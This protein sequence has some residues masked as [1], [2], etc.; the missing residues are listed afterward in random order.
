MMINKLQYK[1][2]PTKKGKEDIMGFI[3]H[4]INDYKINYANRDH[5]RD[6][7]TSQFS[8]FKYEEKIKF[9]DEEEKE[10][11][12]KYNKYIIGRIATNVLLC[13]IKQLDKEL[14]YI[15]LTNYNNFYI[16]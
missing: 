1:V 8:A 12:G 6:E 4:L 16:F 14:I 9:I 13:L 2:V 7:I 10:I 15:D 11:E 5:I 3:D